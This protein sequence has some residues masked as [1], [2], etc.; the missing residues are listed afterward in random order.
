MMKSNLQLI[1]AFYTAF[2]QKDYKTMQSC[3]ADNAV[4]SDPIFNSL[5]ANEV[6]AMWEMFCKNGKELS[7]SINE[8]IQ[9]GEQ[10]KATW[11]AEYL[12]T[13]T[14]KKVTNIIS[15]T[16]D[17]ENGLITNHSDYFDFYKW[18][19]QAFGFNG[20][21][22]GW[23]NFFQKKVQKVALKNLYKFQKNN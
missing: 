8:I 12:F 23:T 13:A 22:L 9:H 19:R 15:A 4:F 6:K 2:Q 11:T 10:V 5:Q 20:L 1:Q 16:F 17:F 18:A 14:N 3:Y 7:I 21:L